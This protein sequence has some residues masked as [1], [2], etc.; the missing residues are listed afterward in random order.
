MT[1]KLKTPLNLG[2]SG[3]VSQTR[4]SVLVRHVVATCGD[5]A[6]IGVE[7]SDAAGDEVSGSAYVAAS[8]GLKARDGERK[9]VS[10]GAHS[11]AAR[12]AIRNVDANWGLEDIGMLDVDM[13]PIGR[14]YGG[15]C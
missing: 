13:R 12:R 3:T 15:G 10:S 8:R 11:R 14:A 5:D 4:P 7:D 2:E 6:S 9:R 1:A